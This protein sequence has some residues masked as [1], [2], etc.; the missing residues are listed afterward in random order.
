M[1]GMKPTNKKAELLL[2]AAQDGHVQEVIA[3]E[4]VAGCATTFDP[5]WEVDPFGGVASFGPVLV[6]GPGAR[7][8]EHLPE[9]GRGRA[10]G[11]KRLA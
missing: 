10:V 6:A 7:H 9:L 1:S 8:D 11:A 5:G 4:S 2:A 3:M